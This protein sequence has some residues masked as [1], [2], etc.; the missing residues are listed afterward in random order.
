MSM[1]PQYQVL[2]VSTGVAGVAIALIG[3][4]HQSGA[5]GVGM[6]ERPPEAP[7]LL[8]SFPAPLSRCW[9]VANKF[10]G[11]HKAH[12]LITRHRVRACLDSR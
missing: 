3:I 11:V 12:L 4:I 1:M 8:F 6:S 10:P 5:L 7:D 9:F 2:V